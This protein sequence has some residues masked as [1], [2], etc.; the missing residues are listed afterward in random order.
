MEETWKAIWT[1]T[2]AGSENHFDGMMVGP[3]NEMRATTKED[4]AK[5]A[6]PEAGR[7]GSF[8]YKKGDKNR[9]WDRRYFEVKQQIL[10]YFDEPTDQVPKGVI[11]LEGCT[12][13]LP[14]NNSQFFEEHSDPKVKECWELW[15]HHP[16]GRLFALCATSRD[17]RS[18]WVKT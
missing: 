9:T 6:D 2:K 4:L 14:I 7:G 13:K 1:Q 8:M 12:I 10:Y 16:Q 11:P 5:I 15:I 3:G 17:D 18:N